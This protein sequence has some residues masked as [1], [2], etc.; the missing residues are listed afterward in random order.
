MRS[1]FFASFIVASIAHA[2]DGGPDDGPLERVQ[3][4]GFQ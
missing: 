3:R 4:D 2:Q 1:L